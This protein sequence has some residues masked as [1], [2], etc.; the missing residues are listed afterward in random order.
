MGRAG[1]GLASYED[2]IQTDAAI[3]PGNSGGALVNMRGELI[4]INTAIFSRS[5]GYQGIG[6][7]IPSNMAQEIMARL[8]TDGRVVRGYLGVGIQPLVPAAAQALGLDAATSGVLV[9]AVEPGSAADGA[10]LRTG[11]VIT[12]I[13]EERVGDV[14]TLRR[15]VA[16]KGAHQ[17]I[18]VKVQRRGTQKA[19][20]ATLGVLPGSEDAMVPEEVQAEETQL[21]GLSV[22]PL[23]D[24]TK[25]ALQSPDAP[26]GLLVVDVEPGSR[27]E[28]AGLRPGQ[29]ILQ[30]NRRNIRST[31][32]LREAV[33]RNDTVLLLIL[34][35]AGRQFV[36]L[37]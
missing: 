6:F 24:Q 17:D 36:V 34:S 30:A 7:A 5:G 14:D 16:M 29:V 35:G 19:L 11:D 13:D 12:A 33:E 23:D 27:A 1:V 37:E 15:I 10:G 26:D 3:N 4:G 31:Q 22:R 28:R 9:N 18:A 21:L 20:R 2:F 25:A 8:V 32:E